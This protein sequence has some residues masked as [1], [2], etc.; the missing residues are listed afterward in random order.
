MKTEQKLLETEVI[1]NNKEQEWKKY[2]RDLELAIEN[3]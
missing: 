3:H 1:Q 2:L